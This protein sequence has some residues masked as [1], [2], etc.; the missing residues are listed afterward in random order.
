M[1][2]TTKAA[3]LKLA[4][5]RDETKVSD[6]MRE[7]A[8]AYVIAFREL[9]QEFLSSEKIDGHRIEGSLGLA[10]G[11][12]CL[13]IKVHQ[14]SE[15]PIINTKIF[16]AVNA[17]WTYLEVKMDAI[18]LGADNTWA[19]VLVEVEYTE[20]APAKHETRRVLSLVSAV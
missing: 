1:R 10:H 3:H 18:E 6:R 12:P 9:V 16:A 20:P 5:A 11:R 7:T 15:D 13:D 4:Y 17:T 19:D 2:S 8:E 14:P